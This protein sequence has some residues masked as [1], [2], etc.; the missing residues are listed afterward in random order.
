MPYRLATTITLALWLAP[1]SSPGAG[2]TY[3]LDQI[4]RA[5]RIVESCDRDNGPRGDGGKAIGPYQIHREYWVD[6]GRPASTWQQ[7]ASAR[8]TATPAVHDYLRRYQ[9][10]AYARADWR[11]LATLHHCGPNMKHPSNAAYL[12][13]VGK[14][15]AGLR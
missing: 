2:R 5:I 15:L 7:G 14:A 4:L 3:T 8:E 13:K 11:T 9:P 10:E 6:S 12:R 1:G